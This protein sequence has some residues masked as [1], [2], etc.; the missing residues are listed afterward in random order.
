MDLFHLLPKAVKQSLLLQG[1]NYACTELESQHVG[2][3]LN[4]AMDQKI[5]SSVSDPL[6][7]KVAKW[8]RQVAEELER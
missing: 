6:Q 1:I 3:L 2:R 4:A 7:R 5:G 8:L